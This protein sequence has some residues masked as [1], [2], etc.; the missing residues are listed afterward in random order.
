[1]P[2]KLKPS[3]KKYDRRTNMTS[4][5]HFYIKSIS[6]TELKSLFNNERTKP[7]LKMKILKE[8]TRRRKLNEKN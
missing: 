3:I 5:Q 1:M 6:E 2:I 7:K 4:L 8:L